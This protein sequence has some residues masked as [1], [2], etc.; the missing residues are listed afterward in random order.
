MTWRT[1]SARNP[2]VAAAVAARTRPAGVSSRSDRA[3]R[4]S[5]RAPRRRGRSRRVLGEPAQTLRVGPSRGCHAD[6]LA[7][8]DPEVHGHVGLGDVLVDLAVGEAGQRLVLGH[9]Q[10]LGLGHAAAH[11][12]VERAFGEASASAGSIVVH[13]PRRLPLADPDLDIAEAGS[14]D[15]MADMPGLARLALA[16]IRRAEHHVAPLIADGVA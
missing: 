12:V 1:P 14:R 9:D 4:P 6:P 5:P 8:H 16:A 10:R 11:R 15:G 2:G 7:D 3:G 13:A